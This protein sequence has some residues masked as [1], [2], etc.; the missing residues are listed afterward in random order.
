ML[1]YYLTELRERLSVEIGCPTIDQRQ[2]SVTFAYCDF[3]DSCQDGVLRLGWE[4]V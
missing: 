4:V 2:E 1:Q 3:I